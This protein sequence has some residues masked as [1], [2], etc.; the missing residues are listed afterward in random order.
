VTANKNGAETY[1]SGE[2]NLVLPPAILNES[3][4]STVSISNGG[5]QPLL[6]SAIDLPPGFILD[7]ASLTVPP[8]GFV[9]YKIRLVAA[10]KGQYS[11]TAHILSNLVALPDFSLNLSGW[12]V[13]PL[14]DTDGDG[15]NDAAEVSMVNLGFIWNS[16]Q[17]ALVDTLFS[18]SK[19]AGLISDQE[20][21]QVDLWTEP[22]TPDLA[23]QTTRLRFEFRDSVDQS[24]IL[25]QRENLQGPPQQGIKLDF[26]M[27]ENCGFVRLRT[28][29]KK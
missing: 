3:A 7:P 10:D 12:V 24:P 23:T 1:T 20:V 18:K 15:L 25:H 28:G 5:L 4:P 8:L 6:I 21:F 26:E 9:D 13:S 14:D 19:F 29:L 2:G 22:P 16:S 27:P 11:G 17:P